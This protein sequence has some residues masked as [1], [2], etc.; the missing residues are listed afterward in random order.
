MNIFKTLSGLLLVM[1]LLLSGCEKS[2]WEKQEKKQIDEFIKAL[3]DT[4]YVL[5]PSGLY[6]IE[7]IPGTGRSPVDYDT[8]YFKYKAKFVD[9]VTWDTNDPVTEPY[10]HVMGT[11]IGPVVAGVEEGLRYMREGGKA[12]LLTPSKLAY[13]FEGIWQYVPG[14]TPIVWEIELDNVKAGPG[15]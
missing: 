15:K 8:V 7:L 10:K 5:Y 9:Y 6:Y 3:G 2:T 13:G 1:A 4:T 14:F 11:D 12:E